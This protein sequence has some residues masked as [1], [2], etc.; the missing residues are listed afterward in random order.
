MHGSSSVTDA[1]FCPEY[2]RFSLFGRNAGEVLS[3]NFSNNHELVK[4]L[5]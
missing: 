1:G 3:S 2:Q 4:P 5:Q